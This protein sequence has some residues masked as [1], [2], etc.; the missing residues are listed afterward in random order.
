MTCWLVFLLLGVLKILVSFL[1]IWQD[2][3]N[4]SCTYSNV[5][6]ILSMCGMFQ[7]LIIWL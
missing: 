3:I 7:L 4:Y 2:D 1:L 5:C 6:G